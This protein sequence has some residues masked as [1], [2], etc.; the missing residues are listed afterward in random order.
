MYI[1]SAMRLLPVLLIALVSFGCAYINPES[2]ESNLRPPP[3]NNQPSIEALL[4]F[5]A[6]MANMTENSQA[7]LCQS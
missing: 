7:E 6:S 3:P 1:L 5:G 2:N 4:A